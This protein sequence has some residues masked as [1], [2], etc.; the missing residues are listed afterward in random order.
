M[1]MISVTDC[2]FL[3][4]SYLL[5]EELNYLMKRTVA[6]GMQSFEKIISNNCFYVDKTN[7]IKE[8]WESE[9]EVTLLTRPRR[10]GKTL[11]MEMLECFFS[12]RYSNR[13]DLFEGLSIWEE[14]KYRNLQGTYP[15]ISLSFA[16]VKENNYIG[17][18]EK[19]NE[20]LTDLY[21][22]HNFLRDSDVLTD[23][24]REYFDRVSMDMR[25]TDATS[26]LHRL[27]DYLCR[28]YG[29]KVIILLDE[30][31]T[32]M[33][34]AY[35]NSYW[36]EMLSFTRS[37][38]NSTF[39]TNP[40]MERG[41]MTGITRVSKESIFSD[42]N[43]L[44]V[45][46]TSTE[47]YTT[48]FGFTEEEV[49]TALDEYGLSAEKGKV[50]EWYDG[51]VFGKRTDIYNP[52]S[53]ISF[54][55]EREYKAYWA[56][57]SS[58]S[59]V[60]ELIREAG[61][62]VKESFEEL[63]KGNT[64]YS[65]ID[66]QVVYSQLNENEAAIWSLLVASGYLKVVSCADQGDSDYET[67][68]LY[69]L[70]ITNGEVMRMFY[71]MTRE[72]FGRARQPYNDFIKAMLLND[73]DAM[74]VYMNRVTMQTF[75]SFD[76]GKNPS[77]SEPERFYHGFVLGL[78]AD[79][80]KDYII[81]SNR[82]SGFGRYDVM[83][84]PKDKS[85]KAVIMEFKVHNPRREASLEETVEAALKQ[86]EEKQYEAV[87]V[88]KGFTKEQIFKYGFAFEGKKVLIG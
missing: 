67:E 68:V 64:I 84:E 39:K 36:E 88:N 19:M 78:M 25:E 45:I 8:W 57:T 27:S 81:T 3:T 5:E 6:I 22:K 66:E 80:S 61:T 2:V 60:S 52:W 50:K 32:P 56:N 47:R 7:F 15:V 20:I 76:T 13:G 1:I 37:L 51:F 71:K 72:W 30:Y 4:K 23:K 69:E 79:L 29:K 65:P 48:S 87:L 14:E 12:N 16:R 41:I 62:T 35:Q 9:D 75:S 54:L 63:M 33:L 86:I 44:K 85:K 49:F 26:A 18:K 28:Y 40:Y 59:L 74:N 11:N 55:S 82:E 17:M 46:T 24:D 38:F 58:N 10:F 83:L 34:E 42:L 21:I 53:I 77:E 43:N 70:A 73:L 31:D